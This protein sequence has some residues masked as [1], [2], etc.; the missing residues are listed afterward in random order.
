MAIAAHP[1]VPH[2]GKTVMQNV[3][4]PPRTNS[5]SEIVTG[6]F[7]LPLTGILKTVRPTGPVPVD[8]TSAN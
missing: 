3:K 4:R 6:F 5:T 8:E 1:V 7:S 2:A